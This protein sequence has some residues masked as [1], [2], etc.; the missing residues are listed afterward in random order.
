MSLP[1]R[2]ILAIA[3][4]AASP[5]AATGQLPDL[6]GKPDATITDPFTQVSGVRELPD[7]RAIVTDQSEQKV[8]MVD[9]RQ[10]TAR[11]LGRAGDGPGEYRFPMAPFAGIGDTTWILDA[12]LRR[13][14]VI[15]S[16]GRFV[17]GLL[18][19]TSGP[20]ASAASARGTDRRAHLY[21]EGNSFNR[22]R[23]TFSDS[24][25]VVRWDPVTGNAQVVTRVWGGGR[26]VLNRPD[27]P[28]SLAR[29]IT[30]YPH[31]DAW[32]P[33]PDGSVAIIKHAPFRIDVV[34]SSGRVRQGSP[35]AHE[36]VA[37][38]AADRQAHRERAA[39][40]RV[41]AVGAGGGAGGMQLPGRQFNDDEF[42]RQ[43]PPFIARAVLVSPEG[44]IWVG[45]S[46]AG[47]AKTWQYDVFTA[48]G[49]RVGS[50]PLN[51]G[52]MVVGFGRGTVY[53]AR[54]DPDDDLIYVERYRR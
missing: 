32:V 40:T 49:R 51:V 35:I 42:P 16:D 27:G 10:G 12:T 23:G 1:S 50:V 8:A 34:D 9:F 29:T 28:A 36:P 31:L 38:T 47:A 45:R 33:L 3:V 6:R 11:Q 19:P 24:V 2:R 25:A 43:M 46:H 5:S 18:L 37:V 7:G 48:S 20:V 14:H 17:R 44:E 39:G 22:D 13:L 53:V 26:V 30:P 54:T 52:T 21:L 41:R 4:L 15:A